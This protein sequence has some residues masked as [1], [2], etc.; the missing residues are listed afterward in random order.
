VAYLILVTHTHAD[1]LDRAQVEKLVKPGAVIVSTPAGIDTL[2]CAPQCG[3][4]ETVGDSDH[5]TVMG[6]DIT[7]VPMY[8]L[9]QG[10]RPGQPFHHKGVGSGSWR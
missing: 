6:I 4:V 5:Q 9:V 3:R 2:N 1:H 7:G 10:S 8:N